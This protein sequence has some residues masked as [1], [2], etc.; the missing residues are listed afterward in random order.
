MPASKYLV[1][2]DSMPIEFVSGEG[3][4]LID[5]KGRK[6][7]DFIGSWCTS[8]VGWKHPGMAEAITAQGREGFAIPPIFRHPRQE[9]FA[10]RLAKLAPGKLMRSFRCTSGSEA[11]DFAIRAARAATGKPTIVT[12]DGV[13]HGHTYGAA[14]L[15]NAQVKKMGPELSGFV[16]L[17]MP[18]TPK[19]A[20][21][22][23]DTFETLAKKR[24]DIAAFMSEP[25][26]TNAGCIIPP[27]GFYPAV[28]DICRRHNI[29]LVMDEVAT[30][31]GRCGKLFASELWGLEP[32]ILCLGKSFTGGYATMAAAL[33]TEDVFKKAKGIPA[34]S[35]FGWLVQDL[36]AVEKNVD[37]IVSQRLDRNAA[38][39]GAFLLEELKS[40]EALKKVKEVRGIGMVFAIEFRLP[41]APL[42]ALHCCRQGLL[43]A[44]TDS[45]TLFF[46]PPLILDR[47]LAKKGADILKRVC[48]L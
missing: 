42:V 1:D 47:A 25:V 36:A 34:Y 43:V 5:A 3:C 35:T 6:Y 41:I 32:D 11:V 16:K 4:H 7:L 31:M 24:K 26:W 27:D 19:Q 21:D 46:S 14:A 29:L 48:G 13:W 37:L 30:C 8:T 9:A 2:Y 12:I 23:L 17:P 38:D 18:R 39:V 33:V 22:V 20:H 15:G 44:F 28:Q 45:K 40:L 10:K